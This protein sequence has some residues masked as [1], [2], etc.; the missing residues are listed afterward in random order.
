MRQWLVMYGKEL[1]EMGRNGKWLW[2]PVVA[3]LLCVM[4][5]IASYFMPEILDK[6]GNMPEGTVIQ[7]PVPQAPEVM[8]QT[9]S[10]F[11][12][13]GILVLVL[14]SMGIVASE[15]ASGVAAMIM[16][17]PVSYAGF[18]TAK[19]AGLL[20]LAGTSYIAGY[21]GA[22]YYTEALIGHVP[23]GA[24]LNA[25]GVYGLWIVF[26]LTVTLLMSTWLKGNGA[27]A[28]VSLFLAAAISIA[29]NLFSRY[30]GAS[31]GRLTE[32]ANAI[33]MQGTPLPLFYGVLL[34][35]VL[36]IAGMLAI[37]VRLFR[38]QEQ[39]G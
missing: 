14:A 37:A 38:G 27:V 18:I 29:T 10:Q 32:H 31:P 13:M 11:G 15:R 5:P 3:V 39:A 9:L 24:A 21:G 23:V 36:L 6:A 4:N 12:T 30:L 34:T 8:V 28:F 1:K 2:V 35:T 26:V 33:L 16:V 7:I 25:M 22:W 20:T 17:K 19:W